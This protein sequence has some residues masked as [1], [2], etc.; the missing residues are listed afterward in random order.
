LSDV[1]SAAGLWASLWPVLLGAVIAYA[2]W[3]WPQRLPHVPEGDLAFAIDGGVRAARICGDV[4]ERS[5]GVLRRWPVAGVSLLVLA[6]T[7]GVAV[8]MG[9]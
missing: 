3:R 2:F 9:S 7:L 1:F 4:F 5:D 6:V 8:A